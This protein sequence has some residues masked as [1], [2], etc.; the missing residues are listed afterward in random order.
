MVTVNEEFNHIPDIQKEL[1]YI[2]NHHIEIGV[3]GEDDSD[4]LMIARVHEFGVDIDVT[5]KMRAY[6]H[7]IGIHLSPSTQ[8][9]KIPER[10][11][12]RSGFDSREK[13]IQKQAEKLITDVLMM[14]TKAK[15]A[16]ESLGQIMVT[17]IQSYMTKLREP[18]NHPATVRNKKSS[19][20]LINSGKLRDEGI[21]YKIRSN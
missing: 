15:P 17:Q 3:F 8:Q 4:L 10:S 19:N 18:A 12:M 16:M 2:M 5:P 21:T 20:P 13:K 11:F 6:L 1:R 7:Y 9:V 14:K